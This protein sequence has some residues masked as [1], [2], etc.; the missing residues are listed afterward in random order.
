MTTAIK[1]RRGTTAQHATFTGLEGELTVDT[2]KD[3]VVVHDGATAGGF[4]LARD[5]AVVHL[6]GNET[7]AGT[8]TFSSDASISGLTVGKG[9][10]A[11]SNNTVVGNL[12]LGANT[13]GSANAAFGGNALFSNTTGTDSVAFGQGTLYFNTTGSNNTALGRSALFQTTA[14]NNTAVGYQAGY[15][16]TTGTFNTAIGLQSLYTNTTGSANIAVGEGAAYYN[17]TGDSNTA[18]G[19]SALQNNTTASNNTAVGYQAGYSNTTGSGTNAIFG[20][21]AGYSNTT[22]SGNCLI[23][24]QAGYSTTGSNNTFVGSNGNYAAGYF[25]TTGSKNTI[26]GGYNGN[27]GGLDIRTASNYI[28]LSDGDGN[29]RQV[30]DGSGNV[31]IG[32]SSPAHRLDVQSSAACILRLKGGTGTNQSGALYINKAGNTDTLAAFGDSAAILGGTPDQA[33][34]IYTGASIPLAFSINNTERMRID[35]SGNVLVG[36]STSGLGAAGR[37]TIEINGASESILGLKINNVVKTYLYQSGE[38]VELNNT[39][40]GSMALKSTGFMNFS[41]NATERMRIDSSGNLLIGT[42]AAIAGAKVTVAG[43]IAT[44]GFV[45]INASTATTIASGTSFLAILRDRGNGGTA[46]VLYDNNSSP[47]VVIVSQTGSTKFVTT[48]PSSTE[49]QIANGGNAI[50]ALSGASIGATNINVSILQ[51]Q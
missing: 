16:N 47:A 33:A 37:G 46:M 48:A 28:V 23:G 5:S 8:K 30:I 10:G 45:G 1:R 19:R 15:S 11:L 32:I 26:L 2:T 40:S 39:G 44:S 27:Q 38:N 24:S 43:Q 41:T 13:T 49:I 7:I 36:S 31:G 21:Q 9:G 20:Y 4:P 6:T 29:P 42:T 35:S 50:T 3:T 51:N 14:S 17:T 12:A 22:G 18:I 25:V 34:L